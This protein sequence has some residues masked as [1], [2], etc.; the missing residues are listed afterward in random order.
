MDPLPSDVIFP[1]ETA[2]VKSIEVTVAVVRMASVAEAV[3]NERSFPYAVPAPFV[4]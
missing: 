4:A 3:V 2:V 1:P